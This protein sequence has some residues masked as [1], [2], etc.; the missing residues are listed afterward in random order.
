MKHAM[1]M[2]LS[3]LAWAIAPA[4]SA[5][6]QE[7]KEFFAHQHYADALAVLLS[8]PSLVKSDPEAKF[9]YAV[10]H[11]QLNRLNEA[12]AALQGLIKTE[13]TPYPE[14]WLYLGKTYHA[15]HQFGKAASYYKDYLRQIKPNH[16]NR[17]MVWDDIRR[18]ANGME[19]QYQMP[20]VVVEN[21]GPG[22]NTSEDEF[23]PIPSPNQNSRLYFSS[24]RTGNAGGRRN[25]NGVTDNRLGRYTSDM[26]SAEAQGNADWGQAKPMHYLLN[27]PQH[28]VLLD[29]NADGTVLYYFKG[30]SP[31]EGQIL[32]DTFRR[33]ED[34][35]MSTIPFPGPINPRLGDGTP[36]F[37]NDTLV[38]FSS[39]R[40]GGY[41][42]LDLYVTTYSNGQWTAARN[43]GL[44]IN[45]PYDETT[46][47]L[48]RDGRTLYFSSNH[49]HR[50]LGGLDVLK[51]MQVPQT[52]R[53]TEPANLGIPINS[54]GDEANFRLGKDGFT[55]FFSSSRKDG[56]G[57]RDLYLAYFNRF[58]PEMELPIA[59]A[60]PSTPAQQ[61]KVE[62]TI[63]R[64]RENAA[65]IPLPVQEE[66]AATIVPPSR[67]ASAFGPIFFTQ[68]TEALSTDHQ[69]QLNRILSL[70]RDFPG[71][72][73]SIT[74]F[75]TEK[76]T[77][78]ARLFK[79]IKKAEQAADYLIQ[80][81]LDGNRIFLR[82]GD[83]G[84]AS[85][86]T[87]AYSLEFSFL[88]PENFPQDTFVPDLEMGL[89]SA[90]PSHKL[91]KNLLYKVQISS[92]LGQYNGGTLDQY[93]D[94]MVEKSPAMAY[95]RYTL[96][97]FTQF[98]AAENFRRELVKAGQK[99]AFIA[100]YVHG[101]RVDRTAARKYLPDF[102]DLINY[103]N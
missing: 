55:A 43:I 38:Y 59:Y 68:E 46:P 83:A 102:P 6:K 70:M 79:G 39:R 15:M 98:E 47:F 74:A 19:W 7:A 75:C 21:M 57:Q 61:R 89:S 94:A 49:P 9:L 20:D 16:P 103:A 97:A 72:Q 41:G 23:A 45:T 2:L 80:A 30:Q 3:C 88:K 53:W 42:G 34:R 8:E 13:K 29:F 58:L 65:N 60:P 22:I 37:A 36:Y 25:A 28:E 62:E 63:A 32:V 85:L 71:L 64:P 91:H 52:N 92:L 93:P 31:N 12:E 1:L 24:I 67:P 82:S 54:A 48:A 84:S 77:L 66:P 100:P 76:L 14:C 95:Y 81:G 69:E 4:Q 18:C 27:S 5:Q 11:Y 78:A 96:G 17:Q 99:S 33:V 90:I 26:F 51:S 40:P 101:I 87:G 44:P 73:L 10:C 50:S 86:K 35:A 56:Y